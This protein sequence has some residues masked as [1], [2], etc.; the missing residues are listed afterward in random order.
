MKENAKLKGQRVQ[1]S[2]CKADITVVDKHGAAIARNEHVF[3][4]QVP[5]GCALLEFKRQI[6]D[7]PG[8]IVTQQAIQMN[9]VIL[10]IQAFTP[11]I[12]HKANQGV[13]F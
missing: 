9:L 2:T 1:C 5:M 3:P 6:F 4:V 7:R 13:A 11:Q 12:A 8:P 10:G